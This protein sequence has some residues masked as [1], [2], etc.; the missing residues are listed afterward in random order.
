MNKPTEKKYK[1][2]QII[3]HFSVAIEKGTI[4]CGSKIPSL[5]HTASQFNCAVSVALQAYQEL[6]ITNIIRGVEKSGYFALPIQPTSGIPAPEKYYHKLISQ[7][8]KPSAYTRKIVEMGTNRAILSLGCA[9]PDQSILPLAK[10]KKS[11]IRLTKEKSQLLCNYSSTGGDS[12]LR[13][14][15]AKLMLERGVAVRK[16][17][18]L[19]TNGCTGA[20]TLAIRCSTQKG[21]TVAIESPTFFGLITILKQLGRK[22]LEIPTA[23]N[24]GL[25]VDKFAKALTEHKIS[26]CI[27]SATFQNPLGSQ[28][29]ED[30]RKTLINLACQYNFTLIEDDIYG[31]C[32]FDSKNHSPAKALDKEGKIIYCSSFSKIVSPGLRIGWLISGDLHQRCEELQ[33]TE[34]LGGPSLTQHSLADFLGSGGYNFHIRKFRKKIALQVFQIKKLILKY[35]PEETLISHPTGGYFLWVE[36]PNQVD[37]ITLFKAA[38]LENIGIVPGP[39]FS[40]NHNMF[41]NCIRVSCG[42]PVSEKTEQ[43]IATLAKLIAQQIS[44]GTTTT[45]AIP[46]E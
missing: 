13:R 5:R 11:I 34:S 37:S 15:I 41:N 42:S 31:E 16:E 33:F 2:E 21:E 38:L 43:G 12:F 19:I 8:S 18:I 3:E 44:K 40:S 29:P 1:Y 24:T 7:P 27:F 46:L 23:S 10:L 26:A 32:G 17:E 36:L 39:V 6:E 45:V 14:E 9:V 4:A 30:N 25:E 35:F 22:V 20:L 28:M